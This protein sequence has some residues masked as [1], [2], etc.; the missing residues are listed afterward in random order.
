MSGEEK[1]EDIEG[2]G[3]GMMAPLSFSVSLMKRDLAAGDVFE[4]VMRLSFNCNK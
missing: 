1:R 2:D 4:V 3:I